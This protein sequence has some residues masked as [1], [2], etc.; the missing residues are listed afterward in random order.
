[1]ARAGEGRRETLAL[2]AT[3]GQAEGKAGAKPRGEHLVCVGEVR[4]GRNKWGT[5]VWI[6]EK[7]CWLLCGVR[8]CV[9]NNTA[10][11]STLA[12]LWQKVVEII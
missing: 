7:G 2:E 6:E 12:H 4:G 9:K 11:L 1:M 5:R 10:I 3:S 8:G